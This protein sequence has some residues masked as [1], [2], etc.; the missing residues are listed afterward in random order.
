MRGKSA[1][2]LGNMLM[3]LGSMMIVI[4]GSYAV[5]VQLMAQ[6]LPED[7]AHAAVMAI[8]LGGLVWLAGAWVDGKMPV[9]ERYS[10]IRQTYTH[11]Q[12]RH[13]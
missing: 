11:Y 9:S 10:L 1:R 8:I 12:R 5:L 4:G 2:F 13:L 6:V 3:V 7:F